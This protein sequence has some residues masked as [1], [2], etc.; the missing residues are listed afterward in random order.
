MVISR[1]PV[2]LNKLHVTATHSPAAGI[3]A[4]AAHTFLITRLPRI[5]AKTFGVP[6]VGHEGVAHIMHFLRTVTLLQCLTYGIAHGLRLNSESSH[7][8]GWS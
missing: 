6:R 1:P 8:S 4:A 5:K 2:S 7:P 3:T